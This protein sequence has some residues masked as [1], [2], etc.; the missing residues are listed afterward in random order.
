PRLP[1][2]LLPASLLLSVGD[3]RHLPPVAAQVDA[4]GP[5]LRLAVSRRPAEVQRSRPLRR[6]DGP[7]LRLDQLPQLLP[8]EADLGGAGQVL[9]GLVEAAGVLVEPAGQLPGPQADGGLGGVEEGVRGG[10]AAL[11]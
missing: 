6:Q 10:A 3:P 7:A 11:A 1:L 4:G 5:R 2:A 9:G 8:A